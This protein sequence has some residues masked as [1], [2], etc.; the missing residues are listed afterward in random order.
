MVNSLSE[1]NIMNTNTFSSNRSSIIN[2]KNLENSLKHLNKPEELNNSINT[3]SMSSNRMQQYEKIINNLL[4]KVK[5]REFT[6]RK[7]TRSPTSNANLTSELK[8]I[9][10]TRK[11]INQ[12]EFPSNHKQPIVTQGMEPRNMKLLKLQPI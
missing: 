12:K 4:D 1:S 11:W 7:N 6:E 9:L 5:G 3:R 8:D 10:Q 2:E